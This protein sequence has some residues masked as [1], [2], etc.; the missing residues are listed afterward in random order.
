MSRQPPKLV[1]IAIAAA[2]TAITQVGTWKDGSTPPMTR[3]SVMIPIVFC[4]SL[5]PWLNA[6]ASAVINCPFLNRMLTLGDAQLTS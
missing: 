6:I 1:P 4:A 5:V 2:L 3:L